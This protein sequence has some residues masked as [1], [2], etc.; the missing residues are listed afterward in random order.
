MEP[1]QRS[2]VTQL[3]Q[4]GH[5]LTAARIA[6]GV[7]LTM[8]WCLFSDVANAK[9]GKTRQARTEAV[10]SKIRTICVPP[11]G[12]RGTDAEG[13]CMPKNGQCPYDFVKVNTAKPIQKDSCEQFDL[14]FEI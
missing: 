2:F 5:S 1:K 3:K 12:K 8:T 11:P 4:I 14:P 10:K 6:V 13:E 7:A 9:Q